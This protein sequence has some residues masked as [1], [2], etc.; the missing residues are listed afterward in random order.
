MFFSCFRTKLEWVLP[1]PHHL[2]KLIRARLL[3][4]LR[5]QSLLPGLTAQLLAVSINGSPNGWF[6]MGTPIK[7]DDLGVLYIEIL[8][9]TMYI[10]EYIKHHI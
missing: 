8:Y 10:S 9:N 5:R 2:K 6:I 1:S 4:S 3:H 7:M